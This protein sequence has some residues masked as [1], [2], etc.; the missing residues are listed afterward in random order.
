[1]FLN[2]IFPSSLASAV[3]WDIFILPSEATQLGL[4]ASNDEMNEI[5]S[6][7]PTVH[8]NNFGIIHILRAMDSPFP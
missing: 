8:I 1:M 6:F 4:S 5:S 7:Y 3:L 2:R